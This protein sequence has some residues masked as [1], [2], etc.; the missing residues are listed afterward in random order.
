M[1]K[2]PFYIFI[3]GGVFSGL[4]KGI[5]TASIGKILQ[6]R[7]FSVTCIK[8][9]PY[10][11][12]DAGS[13]KP[14]EHGE[15]FITEDG[16]QTDEDLGHYERFL[17]INLTAD[18]NISTGKVYGAVINNERQGKYQ[19]KT[20]E[21]IPHLTN[22]VNNRIKK[23][24]Q[25]TKADFILVEIGGTVGEYQSELYYRAARILKNQGEK[26]LFCHLVYLPI[27]EHLGE[28]KTKPAQQ[29]VEML[30]RIGIQPD[31][32]IARAQYPLDEKRKEKI[33]VF[34]NINKKDIISNPDL[35]CAYKLPIIFEQQK[36]A[37]K[38][39]EK[40]NIKSRKRDL[41]SWK[42]LVSK[43][44]KPFQ[45]IK[46]G[47]ISKYYE[48]GSLKLIDSYVSIIEAIKHA[49][50]YHQVK[51]EIIWL[52]S[53][54][55]EKNKNSLKNLKK[56]QGIIIPNNFGNSDLNGKTLAIKYIRE[57]NIPFLGISYGFKIA[58]NEFAKNVCKLSINPESTPVISKST[59]VISKSTP[60]ISKST[61]VISEST[62]VIPESTPVVPEPALVIPAKAGISKTPTPLGGQNIKIKE[63]TLVSKLYKNKVIK[64][65]FHFQYEISDNN[66]ELLEKNGLI[67]SGF[68]QNKNIISIGE[69]PKNKFFIITQF[70]PEFTSRLAKPHPLFLGF[71]KSCL[72]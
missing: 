55:F 51:P 33:A 24:S 1:S 48:A 29:S 35:E 17:D 18:N 20:V 12:V 13:L 45:K 72:E 50:A 58:I 63:K 52:N 41:A 67:F 36:L 70:H 53:K 69:L 30:G 46:I 9:D 56:L 10:L 7:N 11:N 59:P 60:V 65:R 15:I 2:S 8:I 49:C 5:T 68:N 37:E 34:C 23:I 6:S 22:E 21:V 32:I 44:E 40:L 28:M 26:V 4:G 3:S 54:D 47:I 64:E 66:I 71:I 43:L 61:P 14:T 16:A 38:I 62:P 39:F 57:N 31:I 19:G 27:P 25:Q 42:K